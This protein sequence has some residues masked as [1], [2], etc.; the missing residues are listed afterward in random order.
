MKICDYITFTLIWNEYHRD[1]A[2]WWWSGKV[3][4]NETDPD[5]DDDDDDEDEDPYGHLM[6]DDGEEPVDEPDA[7]DSREK[8]KP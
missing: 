5:D 8:Y 6:G 2:K 3:N 1:I 4:D 7:R